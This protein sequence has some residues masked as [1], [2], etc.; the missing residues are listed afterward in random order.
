MSG[1]ERIGKF[2]VDDHGLS[3]AA[4]A[5]ALPVHAM[6]SRMAAQRYE[7]MQRVANE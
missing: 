5:R 4:G 2:S 3:L 7:G 1:R 6:A